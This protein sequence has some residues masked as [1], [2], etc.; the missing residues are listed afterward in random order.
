[1][2]MHDRKSAIRWGRR[3]HILC[4]VVANLAQVVLWWLLTPEHFF[5]PLWSILGWGVGLVTHLSAAPPG[6]HRAGRSLMNRGRYEGVSLPH[7][8]RSGAG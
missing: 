3:V 5:W 7:T 6:L 2:T 4:Y 8:R 1:M